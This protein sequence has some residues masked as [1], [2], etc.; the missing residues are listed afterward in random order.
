MNPRPLPT[1]AAR[2]T[3]GAGPGVH[4]R[5]A[6]ALLRPG[7]V[8]RMVANIALPYEGRLKAAFAS[9]RML[10]QSGGYKVYEAIK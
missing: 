8:C 5:A 4:P 3:E 2:R 9:T 6:A 10:A 7:G 1:T